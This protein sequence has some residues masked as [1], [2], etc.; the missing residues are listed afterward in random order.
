MRLI[1]NGRYYFLS[2]TRRFG[3]S[4]FLDT[5]KDLFEGKKELFKG[6]AVYDQWDWNTSYPVINISL[7]TGV[8]SGDN[9]KQALDKTL[10]RLLK[11]N[12]KRLNVP[13]EDSHDAKDYFAELI[14]AVYASVMCA[15]LASLGFEIIAEDTTLTTAELTSA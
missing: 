2:R 9:A 13:C 7:G 4:L 12:Q 11:H 1:E 15:Y 8:H 5:L 3:K 6:L 10:L 14:E